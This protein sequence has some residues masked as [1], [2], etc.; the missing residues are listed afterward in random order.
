MSVSNRRDGTSLS[1]SLEFRLSNAQRAL[2][3]QPKGGREAA[4][5]GFRS[6]QRHEPGTGSF[7][8]ASLADTHPSSPLATGPR[9]GPIHGGDVYPKEAAARPP[10]GCMTV[11]LW[12]TNT[13]SSREV[14]TDNEK[15][16]DDWERSFWDRATAMYQATYCAQLDPTSP[17]LIPSC[18]Q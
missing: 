4:S 3:I 7:I 13:A 14:A 15:C 1:G 10:W 12:T 6:A 5:L 11:V 9:W 8:R 18:R 2:V 17:W 16:C